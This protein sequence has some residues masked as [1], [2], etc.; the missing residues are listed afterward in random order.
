MVARLTMTE[1]K[2]ARRV[3]RFTDEQ[4][5]ATTDYILLGLKL[6]AVPAA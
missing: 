1:P 4:M 5:G 3:Q 6:A 2:L